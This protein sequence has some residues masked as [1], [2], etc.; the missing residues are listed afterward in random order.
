LNFFPTHSRGIND[1]GWMG[2]ILATQ[3]K[4]RKKTSFG[5]EKN[6]QPIIFRFFLAKAFTV[7][8]FFFNSLSKLAERSDHRRCLEKKEKI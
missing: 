8:F 4:K 5:F 6:Q 3:Q 7:T 2:A 1:G